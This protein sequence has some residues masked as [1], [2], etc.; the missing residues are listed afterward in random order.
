MHRPLHFVFRLTRQDFI[1]Y[2]VSL[3]IVSL[4][5]GFIA[6]TGRKRS[7][8]V[9]PTSAYQDVSFP[10]A[11]RDHLNLEGWYFPAS[12]EK[13][14][15]I[16]HGWGGNRATFLG[17]AQDLQAA[18]FNVL[19]LDLR[20]GTG[21]N[22]YG[23]RESGDLGGAVTWLIQEK[24]FEPGQIFILGNSM[25]GAAAIRYASDHPIGGLILVSSVYD[26]KKTR[27]FF[28]RDH[29]LLF[30]TI[31]ATATQLAERYVYG[32]H[33]VDPIK[34]IGSV[35]APILILHGEADEKAPSGDPHR[36]E[37]QSS[38]NMRFVFVSGGRH[39]YFAEEGS[40]I[41]KKEA[42]GFLLNN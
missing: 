12:N 24:H 16:A 26:L 39:T 4:I 18:G 22:T 30:P 33:T 7:V 36:L 20:G 10:S 31:Y 23:E 37:A 5:A 35:S 21:R 19:T 38:A 32:L 34:L 8:T 15:V 29:H 40:E 27:T 11:A 25:G 9:S 17:L 41:L 42:L 14:L 2:T 1:W 3:L 6:V 13:V 28:A